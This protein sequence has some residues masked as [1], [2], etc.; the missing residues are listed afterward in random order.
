MCGMQKARRAP[1]PMGS[2]ASSFLMGLLSFSFVDPSSVNSPDRILC[3]S[4]PSSSDDTCG[5]GEPA[6]FLAPVRK[7]PLPLFFVRPDIERKAPGR[8][9]CEVFGTLQ[10]LAREAL[11]LASRSKPDKGII[12][13][14]WPIRRPC[15]WTAR[16]VCRPQAMFR[17][18]NNLL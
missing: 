17:L 15:D 18:C 4:S 8:G 1:G 11:R 5:G 7:S 9:T 10:V 13:L 16:G 6:I 3:S 2:F 14:R 12:W